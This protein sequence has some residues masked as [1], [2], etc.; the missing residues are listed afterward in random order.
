MM[1][2]LLAVEYWGVQGTGKDIL[3]VTPEEDQRLPETSPARRGQVS[4]YTGVKLREWR[5]CQEEM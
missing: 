2:I 5:G 3:K 4:M 1:C